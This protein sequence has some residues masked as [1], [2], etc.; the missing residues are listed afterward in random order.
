MCNY[1]LSSYLNDGKPI[2]FPYLKYLVAMD[3]FSMM[4]LG[5]EDANPLSRDEGLLF[6]SA[7]KG[8]T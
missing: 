2:D 8:I 6:E 1:C 3:I 7:S 4:G 5:G